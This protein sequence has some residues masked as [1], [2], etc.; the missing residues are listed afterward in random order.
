MTT[1]TQPDRS[2]WIA[3]YVLCLGELMILL[4]ATIV[5]VALPSIRQSLG[6]SQSDLAWVVN[7][8]LIAFGGLLLL[9]GRLGDMVGKR[10]VFLTG[11]AIFTCASMLCAVAQ[12]QLLL[13]AGRFAQGVGGALT[14][15]VILGMI[16]NMFPEPREQAKAIGV[17]GFVTATGGSAGLIAGG[18]LTAALN[19]RW[20]FIINLPIGIVT[21][22]LCLRHVRPGG[23]IGLRQGADLPG[24]AM[25]TVGLMG[26][27]YAILQVATW[28]WAS[29]NTLVPGVLGVVL[30]AAFV[31]RQ[32]RTAVPLIPLRLFRSRH[33]TVAN[34]LQLLMVAGMFGVF[35]FGALYLQQVLGF[36]PLQVGMAF[37]PAAFTMG[38]TALRFSG[39]FLLRFGVRATLLVSLSVV[40]LCLVVFARTPADGSYATDVLPGMI[41]FGLGGGLAFPALMTLAMSGVAPDESGVASGLLG[42]TYQVGGA[43][44]LAVLTTVSTSRTNDMA[45]AGEREAVALTSGYHLAYLVAAALVVAALL[46]AAIALPRSDSPEEQPADP[47]EAGTH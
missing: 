26:V 32:T 23:H 5:N 18:A 11:L 12:S 31:L 13:V 36:G 22:L 19:W 42:T 3:L 15:A 43:V 40:A 16:V 2:R 8:Y 7:G 6:F 20:V 34:V 46:V 14:S 47:A 4:D 17:Y 25:L 35:F 24:A 10:G 44:G 45:A 29:A 21:A 38:L 27:V 33:V 1:A 41:L 28:G 39:P 30:V 9:A 37:L